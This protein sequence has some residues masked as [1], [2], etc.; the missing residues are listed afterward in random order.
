MS[1]GK[2]YMRSGSKFVEFGDFTLTLIAEVYGGPESYWLGACETAVDRFLETRQQHICIKN[3]SGLKN[4]LALKLI[5]ANYNIQ[6]YRNLFSEA[7][8]ARSSMCF[9]VGLLQS[10]IIEAS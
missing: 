2:T 6:T 7:R 8:R 9:Y 3:P 4:G 10:L 5:F 1:Q